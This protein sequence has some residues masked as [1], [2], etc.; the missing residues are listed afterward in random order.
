MPQLLIGGGVWPMGPLCG[1]RCHTHV[2]E[3]FGEPLPTRIGC[4][5]RIEGVETLK[6]V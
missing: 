1:F 2:G 4:T 5:C 3:R 6:R